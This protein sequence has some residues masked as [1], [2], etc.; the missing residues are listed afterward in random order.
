MSTI[1][2]IRESGKNGTV[3]IFDNRLER[4]IKNR[5][6][7]DDQQMIPLRNV[8]SVSQDRK[9]FGADSVRVV[10]GIETYEWNMVNA[11]EFVKTVNEKLLA[12]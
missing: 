3:E 9:M 5:F 1:F 6:G 12:L 2:K 8:T 10:V 7:K 11:E 4:T